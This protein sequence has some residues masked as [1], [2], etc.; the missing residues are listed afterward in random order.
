MI[1]FHSCYP[2]H[3]GGSYRH[4]M[5]DADHEQM[6]WVLE[7]NKFDLYTKDQD[8]MYCLYNMSL[9]FKRVLYLTNHYVCVCVLQ[10]SRMWRS[11]GRTIKA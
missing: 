1:R 7:F 5:N 9:K 2:W 3:T 8:G 10:G 11:C 6:K 4:L